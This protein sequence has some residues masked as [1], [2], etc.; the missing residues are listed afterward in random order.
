VIFRRQGLMGFAPLVMHKM[1]NMRLADLV[2][3]EIRNHQPDAVFIDAGQGQGVIDRLRQLGHPVMEVPFGGRAL[4]NGR[5]ANRRA[6]M[7]YAVRDW[8]MAGGCLCRQGDWNRL[9]SELCAPSYSFDAAG[10]IVLES[11][12]AIR[13]R[14]GTSPDLADAL[15]LTFA[16]PV[17]DRGGTPHLARRDFDPLA[18]GK[19]AA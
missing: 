3:V 7:W 4:N 9:R 11:K 19:E 15:A 2:A 8:L 14:L 18:W 12:D 16:A 5:F 13:E 1:D 17:M 6:E 10:R